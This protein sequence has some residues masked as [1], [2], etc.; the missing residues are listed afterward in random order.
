MISY[1]WTHEHE[2][3]EAVETVLYAGQIS[4]IH[5]IDI[6]DFQEW[7]IELSGVVQPAPLIDAA[8]ELMN[9]Y[10]YAYTLEALDDVKRGVN[11]DSALDRLQAARKLGY[12]VRDSMMI[13]AEGSTKRANPRL[14]GLCHHLGVVIDS[15][16]KRGKRNS[17]HDLSVLNER[18]LTLQGPK[19][20]GAMQ[21]DVERRLERAMKSMSGHMRSSYDEY[22]EGR[23]EFRRVMSLVVLAV[24]GLGVDQYYFDALNGVAL[25]RRQGQVKDLL[26]GSAKK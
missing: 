24:A 12:I 6:T 18:R 16:G 4:D 14:F 23:K 5:E 19:T 1:P 11:K 9:Q 20:Q 8:N 26:A 17:L 2:L 21:A 25:S 15:E 22:H 7:A 10:P 3:V 13:A